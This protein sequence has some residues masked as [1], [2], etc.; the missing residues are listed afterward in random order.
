[1]GPIMAAGVCELSRCS[2]R[3]EKTNFDTS[4][5]ALRLNHDSL[6]GVASRLLILSVTWFVFSYLLMQSVLGVVAPRIDQTIWGNVLSHLSNAQIFSYIL[7]GG[8]L[9]SIVF[10][11]S[12]VT[13][14]MIIDRHVDARTA[15][16]TSLRVTLKDL[17]VRVIAAQGGGWQSILWAGFMNRKL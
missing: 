6:L 1:M 13:V 11:M 16:N 10:V 14:P 8:I 2:D 15:I 9:A 5:K 7:S 12:V 17:K 3:N 4:L